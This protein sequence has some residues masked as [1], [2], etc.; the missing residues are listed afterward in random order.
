[1]TERKRFLTIA[2]CAVL[3]ISLWGMLPGGGASLAK[4]A[5]SI[6]FSRFNITAN[7]TDS[8]ET[9]KDTFSVSKP[10]SADRVNF[11]ATSRDTFDFSKSFSFEGTIRASAAPDGMTITFQPD[12]DYRYE[13]GTG[14]SL[15]VYNL[16]ETDSTAGTYAEKALVAEFDTFDSRGVGTDSETIVRQAGFPHIAIATTDKNG[17]ETV[18]DAASM[19]A[20]SE[21][22][23]VIRWTLTDPDTGEG[24]YALTCGNSTVTYTGFRP[25]ELFGTTSVYLSVTGALNFEQSYHGQNDVWKISL[26]GFEYSDPEP[27]SGGFSA[28]VTENGETPSGDYAYH[29]VLESEEGETLETVQNSGRKITFGKQTFDKEGVWTFRIHQKKGSVRGVTYDNTVYLAKARVVRQADALTVESVDYTKEDGTAAEPVFRN[30]VAGA[31]IS[32]K[33]T[34]SQKTIGPEDTVKL[35]LTVTNQ[36]KGDAKGVWIR[37][38][39]PEYTN[40]YSVDK[41]GTYGCVDQKE[42]ANW[43]LKSLPA[44]ESVTLTVTVEGHACIP[45]KY[46]PKTKIY[47]QDMQG[48]AFPFANTAKDPANRA[49]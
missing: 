41:T 26:S 17:K 39:M 23:L 4:E 15:M 14:S 9:S 37:R 34:R 3:M 8:F 40:F 24:N 44:G 35:T 12:P 38:Y 18:R 25:K 29:F 21:Q 43:F 16:K 20:G 32:V 48:K 30:K 11:I 10:E 45:E 22:T 7:T 5:E 49:S 46:Q 2:L 36:G 1:M 13:S 47:Y 6:D 19:T 28:S 33:E 42:F 31:E 27:V